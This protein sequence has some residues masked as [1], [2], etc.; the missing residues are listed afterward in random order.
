M[1]FAPSQRGDTPAFQVSSWCLRDYRPEAPVLYVYGLR[2]LQFNSDRW[3]A[4][5]RSRPGSVPPPR[6]HMLRFHGVLAPTQL[7]AARLFPS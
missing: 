3:L 7:C 2:P 6:F 1:F 5:L 4:L